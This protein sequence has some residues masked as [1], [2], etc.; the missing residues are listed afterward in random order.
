MK[1]SV[2][3]LAVFT[4]TGAAHAN[5]TAPEFNQEKRVKPSILVAVS[6]ANIW[7]G[8]PANTES[9]IEE[10]G[11]NIV[12][13]PSFSSQFKV[14]SSNKKFIVRHVGSGVVCNSPIVVIIP[15]T[16]SGDIFD[17]SK[18]IGCV[19]VENGFQIDTMV[20]KNHNHV[21]ASSAM[22]ALIVQEKIDKKYIQEIY[23]PFGSPRNPVQMAGRASSHM[24][25]G[26]GE[27][28]RYIYLSLA[29]VD[30]WIVLVKVRGAIQRAIEC[31][32]QGEANIKSGINDIYRN[33][34]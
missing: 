7:A 25:L 14:I 31:D 19:S 2:F 26:T 27:D 28:P 20:V 9:D 6:N 11:K 8:K 12:Q 17:A 32:R 5:L 4:L 30:D 24:I 33:A 13:L 23:D 3:A 1:F 22:R 15:K 34:H 29:T 10:N 21:D 16:L 18:Q